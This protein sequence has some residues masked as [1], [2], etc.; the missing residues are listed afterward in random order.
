MI[1]SP[2]MFAAALATLSP[3]NV[4]SS[5]GTETEQT[6]A[7]PS[8]A[9]RDVWLEFELDFTP[10]TSNC[11]EV[12]FGA[13][14]NGDGVLSDSECRVAFAIDCGSL[15]VRDV[16]GRS[17]FSNVTTAS[18]FALSLKPAKGQLHDG[19]KLE[20]VDAL[21][22]RSF[23]AEGQFVDNDEPLTAWPSARVRISGPDAASAQMTARRSRHAFVITVR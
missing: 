3:T 8:I 1:A 11:V 18:R 6:F 2:I 14:V 23:L 5:F 16:D 19:W 17:L 21:G 12:A 22:A 10:S 15:A 20:S 7:C 13:D 9:E 4:P